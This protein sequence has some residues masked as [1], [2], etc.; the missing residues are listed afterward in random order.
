ML[1]F[2]VPTLHSSWKHARWRLCGSF[3]SSLTVP[4]ASQR[5]VWAR[6]PFAG[7]LWPLSLPSA[8]EGLCALV[9][10]PCPPLPPRLRR[11]R[12]CGHLLSSPTYPL[13]CRAC[14]SFFRFPSLPSVPHGLYALE[15]FLWHISLGMPGPRSAQQGLCELERCVCLPS[16][17]TLGPLS[18]LWG[19]CGHLFV[20]QARHS[21]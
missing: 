8:S 13:G 9:P 21:P 14:V 11:H 18:A 12:T 5:L 20:S 10:A 6:E 4:S 2:P 19:L 3:L 15:R 1:L 16:L 17:D 7:F